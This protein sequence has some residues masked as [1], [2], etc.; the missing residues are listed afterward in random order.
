MIVEAF[1]GLLDERLSSKTNQ[2]N[3]GLFK[4]NSL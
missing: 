2:W 4:A 3:I 1:I